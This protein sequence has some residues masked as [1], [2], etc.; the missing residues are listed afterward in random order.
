M[1]LVIGM[2]RACRQH[3]NSVNVF[4][5]CVVLLLDLRAEAAAEG[6]V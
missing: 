4:V 2:L 3:T 5:Y 6:I 1:K